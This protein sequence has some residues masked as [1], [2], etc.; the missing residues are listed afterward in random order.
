MREGL[1]DHGG[2]SG[3]EV[4][5]AGPGRTGPVAVEV[6]VAAV[7]TSASVAGTE[8]P[9]FVPNPEIDSDDPTEV[10]VTVRR[11]DG[12]VL[13]P[14]TRATVV[15][16]RNQPNGPGCEPTVHAGTVTVTARP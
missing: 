9:V 6:C 13:V 10:M 5:L 14:A 11:Q 8:G 15:P 2:E 16:E 1:H 7:C 4:V 12:T 3:V